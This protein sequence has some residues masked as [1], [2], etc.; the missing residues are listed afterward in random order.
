MRILRV[1]ILCLLIILAA[2]YLLI[3]PTNDR[4]WKTEQMVTATADRFGNL[5][6]VTN[7]RNFTHINTTSAIPAYYNRTYDL[8][9]LDEIY[10]IVEPFG[11]NEGLAHTFIS[12][13]FMGTYLAVSVE[14]RYEKGETYSP[15]K[16]LL[17]QYELI[18]IVAD[19]QDA[20]KLRTN[21][22]NHSVYLYPINT[23]HQKM[24]EMFLSVMD[25]VN[26]LDKKPEFYNTI[27]NTCTT[28]LVAHVNEITPGKIPFSLKYYMPGYSDELVYD[29][30]LINT[31]QPYENIRETFL[32]SHKSGNNK[33]FSAA[34][35]S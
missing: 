9:M 4:D 14:A 5:V 23:T 15:T 13:G 21:Y 10:F 1:I 2:A 34:I 26:S 30:G 33:D 35:R 32:I 8:N 27:S 7:V 6:T 24:K 17:K 11:E 3:Q 16:G 31:D 25:R 29:L 18:Y 19:E 12:F 28:N 20:I 22:R